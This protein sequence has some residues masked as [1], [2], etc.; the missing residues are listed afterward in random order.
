MKKFLAILLALSMV[1][2]ISVT[3]FATT[4]NDPVYNPD[5]HIDHSDL[6]PADV[7]TEWKRPIIGPT[8]GLVLGNDE[9]NASG[10]T[11]FYLRIDAKAQDEDD[12]PGPEHENWGHD[13]INPGLIKYKAVTQDFSRSSYRFTVPL[14]VCMYAYGVTGKVVTPTADSYRIQNASMQATSAKI[15]RVE[16]YQVAYRTVTELNGAFNAN[17]PDLYSTGVR[18]VHPDAD[19]TSMTDAQIAALNNT[20]VDGILYTLPQ[21]PTIISWIIGDA[22]VPADRPNYIQCRQIVDG[23]AV[24]LYETT[25]AS[26]TQKTY[27]IL[28]QT[29]TEA[30]DPAN[31]QQFRL[32]NGEGTVTPLVA[33][34]PTA[35]TAPG[36]STA[37]SAFTSTN[38]YPT[39]DPAETANL[40]IGDYI[41]VASNAALDAVVRSVKATPADGWELVPAGTESALMTSK[42]LAMSINNLDLSQLVNADEG[43]FDALIYGNEAQWRLGAGTFHAQGSDDG[44][45]GTYANDTVEPNELNLPIAAR[46]AAGGGNNEDGDAAVVTVAYGLG[47]AR[48]TTP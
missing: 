7:G 32:F 21:D 30:E 28:L 24:E 9:S 17:D 48:N 40:R 22:A 1:M 27:G 41:A 2:S 26:G 11:D 12:A 5:P 45:G 33:Y 47:K 15:V 46:I 8:E 20:A 16:R 13:E 14:Y 35:I 18:F 3:A 29:W 10:E 43:K 42:Q 19:P 34:D 38:V 37:Q 44:A 31:N 25:T 23:E 6:K 36:A 39:M 4:E